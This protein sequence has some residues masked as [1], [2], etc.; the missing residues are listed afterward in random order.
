MWRNLGHQD[1]R[2]RGGDGV[3]EERAEGALREV[4]AVL[5][6]A[7]RRVLEVRLPTTSKRHVNP[8]ITIFSI[9][10]KFIKCSGGK[11]QH[12]STCSRNDL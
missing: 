3:R 8:T 5:L 7:D 11:L 12:L 1:G 2:V 9:D 4:E 10:Q 6:L